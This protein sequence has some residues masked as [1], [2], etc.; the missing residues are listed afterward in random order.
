MG[1]ASSGGK[2]GTQWHSSSEFLSK[3]HSVQQSQSDGANP[4][5]AESMV[6]TRSVQ[7]SQSDGANPNTAES[8]V[9]PRS[10]HMVE[11]II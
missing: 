10:V 9:K 4:N 3:T 5:T 8:M 6:K 1:C 2:A 7:Q 11:R